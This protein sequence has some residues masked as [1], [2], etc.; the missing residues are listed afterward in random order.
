MKTIWLHLIILCGLSTKAQFLEPNPSLDWV[1]N[2]D[3]ITLNTLAPATLWQSYNFPKNA[4]YSFAQ[5]REMMGY[6][7]HYDELYTIENWDSNMVEFVRTNIPL[8]PPKTIKKGRIKSHFRS[9]PSGWSLQSSLRF[10]K[11]NFKLQ[12]HRRMTQKDQLFS[13]ALSYEE[14]LSDK[15]KLRTLLGA[16]K[17]SAGQ[18]LILSNTSFP[19]LVSSE[20]FARGIQPKT[21]AAAYTSEGNGLGLSLLHKRAY[22][23]HSQS[24]EHGTR[25][26]VGY[27]FNQGTLG[28]A[29]DSANQGLNYHLHHQNARFFGEHIIYG[30][31]LIGANVLISDVLFEYRLLSHSRNELSSRIHMSWRNKHGTFIVQRKDQRLKVVFSGNNLALQLSEHK[32]DHQS[33][34]RWRAQTRL[35]QDIQAELHYHQGTKGLVLRSSTIV[36]RFP[37]DFALVLA[38]NKEGY[39]IWTS[40]PTAS[41][42]IGATRVHRD[43]AGIHIR[44]KLKYLDLSIHWNALEAEK[45]SCR[46]SSAYSF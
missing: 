34:F 7:D 24:K 23:H 8:N 27:R 40:H 22:L 30:P 21:G 20:F 42:N 29:R 38:Q 31:Q 39:P 32:N 43:F 35:T 33:S 16:H 41:G 37:V 5:Y 45:L 9:S 15:L 19:S 14:R 13:Y 28:W 18:G 17:I 46:V 1:E 36:H 6:I 10:E 2:A 12:L 3:T 4:I 44:S 11:D 26:S 25:I